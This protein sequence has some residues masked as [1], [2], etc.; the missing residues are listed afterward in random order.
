[1]SL[2]AGLRSR[3]ERVLHLLTQH[4]PSLLAAI[5]RDHS[6]ASDTELESF[7]MS[8]ELWG[9]AGSIADQAGVA[10]GGGSRVREFEIALADLGAEQIK[11]GKVN[12]RTAMWVRAFTEINASDI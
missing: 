8:N 12:C 4:E 9:G 5:A 6:W 10:S 7:L 11:L 2:E 1:M 3:W